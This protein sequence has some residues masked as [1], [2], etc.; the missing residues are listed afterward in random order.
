MILKIDNLEFNLEYDEE[1]LHSKIPI[2]F[3]HGF[4]GNLND[5]KFLEDKIPQYF[6]P[7]FIDL[8]GHG[9]TSSPNNA[10]FYSSKSQ[11]AFLKKLIDELNLTRIIICGYSMGGR[12]AL[13]FAY[14]FPQNIIALILE[15]TSFGIQDEKDK[16]E[17]IKNDF[18]I[19]K[20]L[21]EITLEEFLDFWFELPLFNSLNKMP[22]EKLLQIKTERIISNNKIG[23]K[24]SLIGFSTGKMKD[25]YA[26]ANNLSMKIFLITGE[27]DSKFTQIGKSILPKLANGKL[28]IIH[29]VGHNTHLEKPEEFLKLIIKFLLNILDNK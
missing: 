29:D 23:L 6:T 18:Q 22:Q 15:S 11:V 3:L 4:T 19:S 7:I 5:W 16:L 10:E 2:L 27:L 26:L 24:N 14:E 12:L 20:K 25:Y 9:K 28:E 13:D 17:R 21:D 8:I 1:N